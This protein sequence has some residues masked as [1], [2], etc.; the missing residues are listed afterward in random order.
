F[1]LLHV[2]PFSG[3]LAHHPANSNHA[4]V[5]RKRAAYVTTDGATFTRINT[6]AFDPES[7]EVSCIAY[8]PTAPNDEWWLGT[9]KG[10]VLR[11]GDGHLHGGVPQETWT[12]VTP[13]GNRDLISR[14]AVHP[15]DSAI[16]A[17]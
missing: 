12:D 11:T 10:K 3:V 5:G 1:D 17:V 4:L 6:G 2:G 7:A 13:P 16:V 14:I 15:A 9:T 8:A